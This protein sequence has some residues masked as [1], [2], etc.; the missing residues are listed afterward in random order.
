MAVSSVEVDGKCKTSGE[1]KD[2]AD[3]EQTVLDNVSNVDE[4]NHLRLQLTT[5]LRTNHHVL[6]TS[7]THRSTVSQPH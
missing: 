4:S 7:H 5:R 1:D 3:H 6:H 2:A